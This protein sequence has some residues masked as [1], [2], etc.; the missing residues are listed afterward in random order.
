MKNCGLTTI[1]VSIVYTDNIKYQQDHKGIT[2]L[3]SFS[4]R[5]QC[6]AHKAL[7]P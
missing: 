3:C 4:H 6:R 5:C 1:W 2:L 7:P